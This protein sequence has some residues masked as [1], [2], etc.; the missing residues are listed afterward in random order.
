MLVCSDLVVSVWLWP[1]NKHGSFSYSGF[2]TTKAETRAM[3]TSQH[4]PAAPTTEEPFRYS[5]SQTVRLLRDSLDPEQPGLSGRAAARAADVP[6]TTLRYWQ[7]RQQRTAAPPELVAFFESPVGLAFLKRLLLA[8]HLVFQQHGT[9]GLRPL[10]RFLQLAQLAPFV[11]A[12]YG[13]HQQLAALLQDLFARYDQEQRAQLAPTMSTKDITL[14]EDENFHGSQ[15]CLVAIEPLSNFLVLESYQPQRDAD[16]WNQAV[17]TALEGLPV[18]V[19]QVTSDLA[20]GLQTHAREGLGAQ[21]SADLMHLQADLHKATS[22][23]WQRYLQAA[24]QRLLEVQERL[25]DRQQ[26]YQQYQSGN[27]P[28]GRPPNFERDLRWAQDAQHYWQQQVQQR[29]EGQQQ[30]QQA[31]RGLA[32]DYHPF[33]NQTGQ[34]VSAQA[35]QQRL[36]QR[37]ETISRLA[38][39]AKVSEASRARLAKARR[40][41]PRLLASLVWFW[42]NLRL[43]VESLQLSA[44]QERAVYEQLLPGLYW[45]A[46]A[47]RGR[48]AAEKKRLR[49]LADSC[50]AQAWSQEGVLRSLGEE[51]REHLKQVCAEGVSRFVRSSSCVEGRNGQLSL[52]HHGCHALSPGKLKALTILHNYFIERD[53]GST[54]AER[55]FGKKPANLFEWLLERFPDPPRPAKQ[56]RKPTKVPA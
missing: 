1:L 6:H 24:Q 54:A 33:D 47:E 45:Q 22:L 31:I 3:L 52:H 36:Q 15:P 16:T 42:H 25:Q 11:A 20:Q 7:Q 17:R 27:R 13:R 53:D 19:I 8:L 41:L 37:F 56:R 2:A 32:D 50:L 18:R 5:R 4:T 28:A 38:E 48:S 46:A 26:R 9:V 39:Q 14:C 30:L 21:H 55:F 44:A 12:S 35:M 23:P 29:Q 49:S 10:C 34:E 51:V 43:L 40:V